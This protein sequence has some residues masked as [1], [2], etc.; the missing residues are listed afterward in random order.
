VQRS[1]RQVPTIV[2]QHLRK[3]L[4]RCQAQL[5]HRHIVNRLLWL[6]D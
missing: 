1:S 4:S 2:P 6:G 5:L 3:L